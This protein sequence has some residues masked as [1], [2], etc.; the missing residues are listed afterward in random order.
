MKNCWDFAPPAAPNSRMLHDRCLVVAVTRHRYGP[1]PSWPALC[2]PSSHVASCEDGRDKPGH[3][4][5]HFVTLTCVLL[6]LL[7]ALLCPSAYAQRFPPDS[8]VLNVRDFG[9][10]G[11]GKHDDTSA[12]LAAIAA[13]GGDT[14][15]SF[16]QTKI[17]YLPAGTYLVSRPLLKRYADG[18]FGSGMTLI[19]QSRNDT[20]IRLVDHAP[21][22]GNSAAP[23]GVIMTTSKLL[24]G[25]PTSGGKDYTHKGEG[26]DA[27]ENFVEHLTIDVGHDNPGAIGIDYLANNI[28]EIRDVRVIA[29]SGSGAI[30][31]SMQRKWPGPALLNHVEVRGFDTGI[32][33]AN[34]EYGMTLD[35]VRLIGQHRIGLANSSNAVSAAHLTVE[36]AP[37]AIANTAPN[38]LVALTDSVLKRGAVGRRAFQN[39]GAITAFGLQLDGLAAPDRATS[40]LTGVLRSDRWHPHNLQ[41]APVLPSAPH[42]AEQPVAQWMNVLHQMQPGDPPHDITNALRRAMASGAATIYLPYGRYTITNAIH[43]PPT[44]RRIVSMNASIT[45]PPDRDPRFGRT[46]GMFVINQ[47]GPPLLIDRVV[48]D[49]TNLGDQLAVELAA[50]RDVTLRDIVTA[51]T[52]LLDRKPNGGRVF[53]QDTCCGTMRIAGREPVYATQLDT[54]GGGTRI[55]ND[56]SPLTIL[57]LKTEG[58]CTVLDNRNGARSEIL[59]G[60]LYVVHRADPAVPAFRNADASLRAAFLEES[61]RPDSRYTFYLHGPE[62]DD[63]AASDFPDRGYGRIVPWLVAGH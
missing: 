41:P 48:F 26:N 44:V 40:P 33:V 28:G 8:G 63:V 14:G 3:D 55:L 38:G 16:W 34:T 21:G 17:V 22:F 12:I 11:D 54:E 2:R 23:R 1:S 32:A 18:R 58:D 42:V 13:E 60:L 53:I 46:T 15:P 56:G 49:M 4:G 6:A 47:P 29:P 24:D 36:S 35:D 37:I 43:I 19:G 27:Y 39:R 31:I 10:K 51:G 9:A 5:L 62:G 57:G 50:H 45:V 20:T 59:G 52:S 30:G 7:L 25:T 61:F